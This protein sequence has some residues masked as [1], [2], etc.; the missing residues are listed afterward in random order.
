MQLVLLNQLSAVWPPAERSTKM[1]KLHEV[2]NTVLLKEKDKLKPSTYEA[3]KRYLIHLAGHGAGIGI[4]EPCQELYDSFVARAATVDLRFQLYHAVRLVDAEAGTRAYTPEGTLY[5]EPKLPSMAESD[6]VFKEFS[7]PIEDESIDIG[8][9]ILRAKKEMEHLQLSFST[10][11]QY[12]QAW[13][14]LYCFLYVSGDSTFTRESVVLFSKDAARKNRYGKLHTWK[15]KIRR[16]CVNILLKVAETGQ[17]EWKLFRSRQIHCPDD[18]LEKLRQQYTSFLKSKNLENSTIALYDY[19]FRL[20]M[21]STGIQ[22]FSQLRHLN[23]SQIQGMLVSL[24]DRLCL[25]S[26]GTIY[27]AIRQTLSFLYAGG[28]TAT[29]FS[30]MI[31]TPNYQQ[32]HLRPYITSADEERLFAVINELPLRTGAMMRL[33]LRLG[34][35]DIDICNLRFD[36]IDWNNDR[37]VLEQEKTG[38]VLYLPLL[39]DVGNAIMDYNIKERPAGGRDCPYVFL[40]K[41]APY[42]KLAS[43]YMVCSKLFEKAGIKTVNGGSRGVHV[44]RH[45]LTHKLL[46]AKVPYQVITDT[47]G[48]ASKESDKPYLSMEEEMLRE[49]PLDFSLIGQKYWKEGDCDD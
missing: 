30:G 29:D 5:N 36:Q 20:L 13:R 34:I 27:P 39:E 23:P 46:K 4:G 28:F 40:R 26:R 32:M 21:E 3:R 45:T 22:A 2:I 41:Q 37:I 49:C 14:E 18:S 8:H 15:L 48:H 7:F 17:F 43:M 35:R 9:L 44:C 19:S 12:M 47:L 33:A 38:M 6:T 16:R 1:D 10:N 11:W 25:N 24:S 42:T 31:M